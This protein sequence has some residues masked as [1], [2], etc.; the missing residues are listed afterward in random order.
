MDLSVELSI[1]DSQQGIIIE[2][3]S[4]FPSFFSLFWPLYY[5]RFVAVS[6]TLLSRVENSLSPDLRVIHTN[7]SQS[8]SGQ[9]VTAKTE[10]QRNGM[11]KSELQI[12]PSSSSVQFLSQFHFVSICF[13]F[14][15]C[16][17]QPFPL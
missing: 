1:C 8:Q 13:Y 15:T 3:D 10:P 16:K 17:L 5:K 4:D 12:W 9:S 7:V 6:P 2:N 14:D 11:S